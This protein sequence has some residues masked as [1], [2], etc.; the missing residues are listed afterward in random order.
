[1]RESKP[2]QG[3][4]PQRDR[5][6][7]EAARGVKQTMASLSD[8]RPTSSQLKSYVALLIRESDRGAAVM[9][10]A[11]VENALEDAAKMV[12]VDPGKT[13]L[14]KWFQ[15]PNAPFASFSA[16][17]TLGRALGI[18]DEEFEQRLILIKNIRNAFAH[19][20]IPLTFSHPLLKAECSK[21]SPKDSK[22]RNSDPKAIFGI[23]C[24]SV[25]DMLNAFTRR[26]L[27][28][29]QL[30]SPIPTRD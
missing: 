27:E 8:L 5:S 13:A 19:A 4:A 14:T 3:R 11:L 29:R 1:M 7:H 12:L 22:S 25:S 10:G 20:S 17:I 23:T 15:G 28:I 26:H 24:L 16:K 2:H 30:S 6:E 18:Y 21:F 9:A